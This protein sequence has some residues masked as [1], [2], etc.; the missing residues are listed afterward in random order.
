[1]GRFDVELLPIAY[2][3]LNEIYDYIMLDNP[4]AAITMFDNIFQS[5]RRLEDFPNS[6]APLQK[7]SLRKFNFRMVFINNIKNH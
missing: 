2:D 3:D 6:G 7:R 5:L 1:M 4:T